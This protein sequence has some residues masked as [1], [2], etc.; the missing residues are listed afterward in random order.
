MKQK[1]FSLLLVVL[2]SVLLLPLASAK[3]GVQSLRGGT[4]LGDASVPAK[5]NKWRH[6]DEPIARQYVQQPPLIPHRVDNYKINKKFN[7]C[8][9][10]HSWSNYRV[11]G[12]TKVGQ[13]H[14]M[15]HDGSE[16]SNIAGRRYFCLQC[17]VP[18]K[19]VDPL[20]GNEFKPIE[21]LDQ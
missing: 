20:V 5:L 13:S 2:V 10:C 16:N 11:S 17:H 1:T 19:Q 7:K 9:T 8:L 6:D 4:E 3:E 21:I 18:Q 12:A 15:E 14:F